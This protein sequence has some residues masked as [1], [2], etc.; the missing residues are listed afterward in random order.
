MINMLML[1]QQQHT[2]TLTLAPSI[3]SFTE[4]VLPLSSLSELAVQPAFRKPS[5]RGKVNNAMGQ[6]GS[7]FRPQPW[8]IGLAMLLVLNNYNIF[9]AVTFIT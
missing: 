5:N 1:S 3:C 6:Y 2:L 8:G 9:I 4:D 7:A